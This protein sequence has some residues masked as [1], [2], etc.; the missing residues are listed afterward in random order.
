M[1][2]EQWEKGVVYGPLKIDL[3][4]PWV[5]EKQ[6]NPKAIEEM[7]EE[8]RTEMLAKEKH[9]AD[10][11][12]AFKVYLNKGYLSKKPEQITI[13]NSA[14]S[15]KWGNSTNTRGVSL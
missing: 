12:A 15:N 1:T 7:I 14:T 5:R 11:A 8:F 3:I 6:Y 10:F 4:G 13:C 9:Y 2:L